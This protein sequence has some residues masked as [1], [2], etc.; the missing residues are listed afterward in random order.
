MQYAR[1][2]H[3]HAC[4]FKHAH[5]CGLTLVLIPTKGR[6]PLP[7]MA[8]RW[9]V[10]LSPLSLYVMHSCYNAITIMTFV[11]LIRNGHLEVVQFLVNE[12]DTDPNA[13]NKDGETALHIALK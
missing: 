11:L 10:T 7:G 1:I 3:A 13:V 2:C 4:C 8:Y 9:S 5:A 12:K 6:E